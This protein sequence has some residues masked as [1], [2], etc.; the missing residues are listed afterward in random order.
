[1]LLRLSESTAHFGNFPSTLIPQVASYSSHLITEENTERS[2]RKSRENQKGVAYPTQRNAHRH[3]GI[4]AS[5]NRGPGGKSG[6]G[7]RL[8]SGV[9]ETGSLLCCVF[10]S[11]VGEASNLVSDMLLVGASTIGRTVDRKHRRFQN[12]CEVVVHGGTVGNAG[13]E[14]VCASFGVRGV[15]CVSF[16]K[17]RPSQTRIGYRG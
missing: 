12:I 8:E 4:W 7:L 11:V 1:M 13:L 5:R 6:L 2:E 17:V 16:F 10:S 3:I 14:D 15:S 9:G